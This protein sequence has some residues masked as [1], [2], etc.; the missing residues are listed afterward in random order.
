MFRR[1]PAPA[2]AASGVRA[3]NPSGSALIVETAVEHRDRIRQYDEAMDA[4]D[5]A[6][7]ASGRFAARVA[8][9][10]DVDHAA[11]ADRVH[12]LLVEATALLHA[13]YVIPPKE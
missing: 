5:A 9:L 6:R 8:T 12:R 10:D 1:W 11:A 2:A 13:A 4:V 7:R 3:P